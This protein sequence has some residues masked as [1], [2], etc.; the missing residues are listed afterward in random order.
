MKR[1]ELGFQSALLVS[2]GV[3]IGCFVA[4]LLGWWIGL[5]EVAALLLAVSVL[6]LAGRLWG[7][8]ALHRVELRVSAGS[9]TLSV[10]QSVS[11][12][13][14]LKNNKALPLTWLELCQSVPPRDCLRPGTGFSRMTCSE[15]ETQLTGIREAW[16]RRFSF[17]PPYG[18][19]AWDTEWTAECRG[20]YRPERFSLQSGDG[21]GLT[22]IRDSADA[23][24]D[25]VFV[26]WPKIIPVETSPFL[27]HVW[28]G[29]VGRMGF[30][31]DPTV[32]KGVRA[33]QPG[34]SW[35]RMDWRTA[36]RTD[37]LMVKQFDTVMPL[38][39]LFMP[40]LKSIQDKEAAISLLASLILAL[41]QRGVACG[42]A[43]PGTATARPLVIA[44][45]EGGSRRCLFALAEVEAES[46]TATFDEPALLA[47]AA[48]AGQ[49]WMLAESAA[50]LSCPTTGQKLSS[51]AP[52][53]ISAVRKPGLPTS[54][55]LSMAELR[56]KGV[57]A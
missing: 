57:N 23:L 3:I 38:N 31:E 43:L 1:K 4:S 46:A 2:P 35:K 28:T 30:T 19:L 9:G 49:V 27:R 16:V 5:G 37:E 26:V 17:F 13:Y 44:P 52:G 47:A 7:S 55:E 22:Q 41:E 40:D 12:H 24:K 20:V 42:L 25:R 53:L 51:C 48:L 14:E 15:E 8:Y 32:M 33:Y 10:G 29:S 54:R 6:G 11:F 21:F 50:E 36:A 45:E 34:D 56:A 39:V 18:T